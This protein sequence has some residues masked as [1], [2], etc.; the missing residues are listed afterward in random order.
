MIALL[1]CAESRQVNRFRKLEAIN[2]ICT[3]KKQ[4]KL[5]SSQHK[6]VIDAIM[7]ECGNMVSLTMHCRSALGKCQI[8]LSAEDLM[9]PDDVEVSVQSAETPIISLISED[10]LSVPSTGVSLQYKSTAPLRLTIAVEEAHYSFA[11]SGIKLPVGMEVLCSPPLAV[12]VR[13]LQEARALKLVTSES[14][15]TLV[16]GICRE[17]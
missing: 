12:L 10:E 2:W 9:K 8:F 17:I 1:L 7:Q 16:L 3:Q 6:S 15:E 13:I 14:K 5:F 11:V 4:S